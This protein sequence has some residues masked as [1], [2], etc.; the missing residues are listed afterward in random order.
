MRISFGQPVCQSNEEQH[1]KYCNKMKRTCCPIT[2]MVLTLLY[3]DEP[4][5][6]FKV[7][8]KRFSIAYNKILYNT[9]Q[10]YLLSEGYNIK[11]LAQISHHFSHIHF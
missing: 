3:F 8:K 2:L 9:I 7:I 1:L 6:I 11:G 5:S 10:F 4:D